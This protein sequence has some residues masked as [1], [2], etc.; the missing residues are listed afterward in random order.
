MTAL[1]ERRQIQRIVTPL[2]TIKGLAAD[3]E[4]AAGA[5]RVGGLAIEIHPSQTNSA[6][7]AKLHPDSG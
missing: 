6:F 3:A 5:S 4:V 7:P 1:F 2:P